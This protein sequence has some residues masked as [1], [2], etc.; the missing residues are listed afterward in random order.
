MNLSYE[1]KISGKKKEEIDEIIKLNKIEDGTII[2]LLQGVQDQYGYLPSEI[3]IYLSNELK[4][5]LAEIYGIATF[6]TQFK[7]NPKGKYAITCCEGTA[8]HIKGGD[9]ILT[10]V[11]SF[12]G[13][14]PGENTD[15][16]LFSLD[17]AACFG[18]CAISP[19]CI[20]NNRIYGNLT[21]KK[22]KN[23]LMKLREEAKI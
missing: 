1:Q 19:V 7:L 16:G 23:I 20:I 3:L 18:C 6:Y 2:T 9:F 4:V 10:Y 15:D 5:P 21:L 12:L 13:I 22:M 17:S 8:C 14:R 11:Q